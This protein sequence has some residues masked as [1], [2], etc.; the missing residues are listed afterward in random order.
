MKLRIAGISGL[1]GLG[2][3]SRRNGC[4]LSEPDRA[5]TRGSVLTR[6]RSGLERRLLNET[7]ATIAVYGD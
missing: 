3:E 7:A 6:L 1:G 2:A 4:L 5:G